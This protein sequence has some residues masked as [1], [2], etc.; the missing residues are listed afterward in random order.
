MGDP[1]NV[2]LIVLDGVRADHMSCYGYDRQT[3]PFLDELAREGVR[4]S[5]MTAVAPTTLAALAAVF[6]G[7]HSVTHGATSE[8]PTLLAH[9]PVLA[10]VL[11]AAGYRTA[12]FCTNPNVAPENGLGRGFDAFVT[13]RFQNQ[14]AMRAVSFG[15]RAADRLLR[16]SDGGARR[17]NLA[18]AR[19]L[20]EADKP[21]FAYLHYNEA[22]LP[23]QT[24]PQFARQFLGGRVDFPRALEVNSK[25]RQWSR[26]PASVSPEDRTILGDL[27]DGALRYVDHCVNETVSSLRARG[28]WERTLVVVT[29][30]HGVSLGEQGV[31]GHASGLSDTLLRVPL[32]LRCPSIVPQGFVIDELAQTTDIAPTVCSLLGL[33]AV[34]FPRGR[35]LLAAER[36][37][38]GPSFV[39]AERFRPYPERTP[40]AESSAG[41]EDVRMKA[42]RTRREKFIWRS[43]EVNE[44]YDVAADPGECT[45]LIE[46]DTQ[47]ADVLRRQLFDWLADA[48]AFE[49]PEEEIAEA[50]VGAKS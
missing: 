47:R 16:R 37:T 33:S 45:N 14:L 49:I 39:I 27:Y 8:H 23:I 12:A 17:T 22:R 48:D 1:I 29:A 26:P 40:G 50:A 42:I 9:H 2:L 24:P 3:T 7:L 38:P 28:V 36:A 6:T 21:F 19:W 20:G 4:F 34:A 31:V 25:A 32:L 15:R 18:F 46:H 30:D 13:Q 41:E 10:E 44:L 35:T 43:D 5:N 11:R